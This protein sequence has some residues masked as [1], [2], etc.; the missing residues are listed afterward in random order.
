M[1]NE[2]YTEKTDGIHLLPDF[3]HHIV[4][5]NQADAVS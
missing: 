5:E 3:V 1:I 4:N 2:G